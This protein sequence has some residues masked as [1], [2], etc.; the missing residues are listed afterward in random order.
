METYIS[1][2]ERGDGISFYRLRR[3]IGYLVSDVSRWNTGKKAELSD[4][5]KHDSMNSMEVI[6]L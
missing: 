6:K 4:R 1:E 3:I 5:V 2:A